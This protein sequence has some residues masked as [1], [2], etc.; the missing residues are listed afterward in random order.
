MAELFRS[1]DDV[2]LEQDIWTVVNN[3]LWKDHLDSLLALSRCDHEGLRHLASW[4]LTRWTDPEVIEYMKTFLDSEFPE[5][6]ENG[7]IGLA[8]HAPQEACKWLAE[9]FQRER[10]PNVLASI[11]A[12][13]GDLRC[14]SLAQ[15]LLEAA[16]DTSGPLEYEFLVAAARNDIYES[17]AG[18]TGFISDRRRSIEVAQLLIKLDYTPALEP[19]RKAA[20]SFWAPHSVRIPA[21]AILAVFGDESSR[22]YL[23]GRTRSWFIET[24]LLAVHFLGMIPHDW[25]RQRLEELS[26]AK[27]ALVR[28]AAADALAGHREYSGIP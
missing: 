17:G 18:L 5:V 6:R 20:S 11:A 7:V 2:I 19:A 25:A 14:S 10:D 3:G 4:A 23:L 9:L 27:D 28:D 22:D 12:A 26:R 21:S 16:K 24:K 8:E 13:A 15:L 1:K